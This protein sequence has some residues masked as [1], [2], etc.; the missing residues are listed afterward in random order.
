MVEIKVVVTGFDY[1][2]PLADMLLIVRI[3]FSRKSCVSMHIVTGSYFMKVESLGYRKL[4]QI[5]VRRLQRIY[6]SEIEMLV[7]CIY[8][9]E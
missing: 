8:S 9:V 1:T 7:H 4:E 6:C 3:E 2:G 5:C